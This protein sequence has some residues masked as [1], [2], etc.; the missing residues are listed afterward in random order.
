MPKLRAFLDA[1]ADGSIRVEKRSGETP[2]PFASELVFQFTAAYLYEWDEPRRNASQPVRAAVDEDLL[3][4]LLHSLEAGKGL[5]AQAVGRVEARLRQRGLPPRTVEEM[6]ETLRRSGRSQGLRAVR[7]DGTVRWTHCAM[8]AG[9]S[10]S[11]SPAPISRA[12]GFR[13]RSKASTEPRSPRDDE[14]DLEAVETIVR[15]FLRTHALVGLDD[16]IRRYPIAPEIARELL[17]RWVESR[18][19]VRIDEGGDGPRWSERENL[20]EIQ[21]LSVANRRRESVAV[22]PEVFADFVL[23]RQHL[24]PAERLKGTEGLEQALEQLQGFA[25]TAGFWESEL[26]PRRV[27]DYRPSKL[28]ELFAGGGWLWRASLSGREEPL[29]AI[30]ARDFAGG[31]PE[32]GEVEHDEAAPQVLEALKQRGASFAV[33]LAR[34]T[35]LGPGPTRRAVLRASGAGGGRQRSFRPAA[36]RRV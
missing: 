19:V 14:P 36:A 2:S 18:E 26:L 9:R 33:D 5:D 34:T 3:D 28:D 35:N 12:A 8:R 30:V 29:T 7:P 21:R 23:R 31:W 17:E 27:A 32:A 25:A 11:S 4:G 1:V 24:H 16:L 20:T 6:S 15:R 10:G 22:R 13:P